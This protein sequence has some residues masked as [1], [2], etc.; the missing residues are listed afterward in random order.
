MRRTVRAFPSPCAT[1]TTRLERSQIVPT[2][3]V[4]PY[5]GTRPRSP[6]KAGNVLRL[7]RRGRS[8]RPAVPGGGPRGGP[9]GLN[10][11]GAAAAPPARRFTRL[12][13]RAAVPPPPHRAGGG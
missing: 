11:R 5:H 6:P 4:T 7:S 2:P 9:R 13:P 12:P 1:I 8:A 3:T 10:A